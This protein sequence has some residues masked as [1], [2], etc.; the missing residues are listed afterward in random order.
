MFVYDGDIYADKS[1]TSAA[2]KKEKGM[3][4][5]IITCT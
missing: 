5:K 2:K 4:K 3:M 1:D